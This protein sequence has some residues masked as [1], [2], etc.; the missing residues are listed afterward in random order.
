[1]EYRI[2]NSSYLDSINTFEQR[3]RIIPSNM[4]KLMQTRSITV[5]EKDASI[6]VAF[7]EQKNN[8]KITL[9]EQSISDNMA[10]Y[11][12]DMRLQE[13]P[14]LDPNNT[15]VVAIAMKESIL[16]PY[17]G[18]YQTDMRLQESSLKPNNT[19]VVEMAAKKSTLEPYVEQY[20]TFNLVPQ[21]NMQNMQSR[22]NFSSALVSWLRSVPHS[23]KPE[24]QRL[25][26]NK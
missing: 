20:Q 24:Y 7:F 10:R 4:L 26:S 14:S 15:T 1:M 11:I 3:H 25:L 22:S 9:N 5:N 8:M 12:S 23:T 2:R 13:D 19:T 6:L 17:V 18:Q 16:V 21:S